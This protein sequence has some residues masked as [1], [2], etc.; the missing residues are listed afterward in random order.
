MEISQGNFNKNTI[1]V[2]ITNSLSLQKH[3]HILSLAIEELE[4]Q[5]ITLLENNPAID[6]VKIKPLNF[7]PEALDFIKQPNKEHPFE[8]IPTKLLSTHDKI[9]AEKILQSLCKEG[10]LQEEEKKFLVDSYGQKMLKILDIIQTY[11]HLGFEH[12]LRYWQYLLKKRGCFQ[13][14]V[15]IIDQFYDQLLI[16]DFMPII[17]KLKMS[18]QAFK[19]EVLDLFKSLPL[20]PLSSHT[21]D[22]K[23]QR[24]DAK[25]SFID[26]ISDIDIASAL[27]EF[28]LNPLI[29]IDNED[30]KRFY[31]PHLE[32]VE[33]FLQGIKKRT[34]TFHRV[35][36]KLVSLQYSYLTGEQVHPLPINPKELAQDLDMHP[37]TLARCLQNKIILTPRGLIELK[38]LVT[39]RFLNTDKLTVIERLKTLIKSENKNKPY[40]DD[41]LL[42]LLKEKGADISRR[43]IVKYRK[44]LNIPDAKTRAF[45]D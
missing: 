39:P 17:K 19:T 10:F 12:R 32:E 4:L 16:A 29:H 40:T 6:Q 24:I 20:S 31:K 44:Q 11:T 45:F 42:K 1:E 13:T 38:T 37:S 23:H 22:V 35:L 2:S 25:I 36:T 9:L 18:Q 34:K 43:T 7:S 33:L 8:Q 30:V 3:L 26:E 41:K 21:H 5:A 27:P 14:A 28:T 15:A